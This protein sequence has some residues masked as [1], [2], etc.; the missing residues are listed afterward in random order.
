MA[1]CE[2]R[3]ISVAVGGARGSRDAL[4]VGGFGNASDADDF[5]D[6]VV[7][8][9]GVVIGD[10][11]RMCVLRRDCDGGESN[12]DESSEEK[13][14]HNERE[15]HGEP[16]KEAWDVGFMRSGTHDCEQGME[17]GWIR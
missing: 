10:C 15:I 4:A 2:D 11:L 6:V 8:R 9:V 13:S 1:S 7:A 17:V 14:G 16:E 3:R 5:G 12:A